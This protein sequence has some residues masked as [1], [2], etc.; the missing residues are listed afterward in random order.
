MYESIRVGYL[1]S[2]STLL[3]DEFSFPIQITRMTMLP[4]FIVHV[5]HMFFVCF[6]TKHLDLC[7]VLVVRTPHLDERLNIKKNLGGFFY[8]RL[9]ASCLGSLPCIEY[10]ILG[11]GILSQLQPRKVLKFRP[12][13]KR[14]SK[15]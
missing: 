14:S 2:V 9:M 7:A 12:M 10:I 8:F 1:P 3:V 11:F 6:T 5:H 4:Y 15:F 13:W